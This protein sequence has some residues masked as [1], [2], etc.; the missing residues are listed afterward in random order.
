MVSA[1]GR[2]WQFP[3]QRDNISP[4]SYWILST[5]LHNPGAATRMALQIY[6]IRTRS[7][8]LNV[9]LDTYTT[10]RV[11]PGETADLYQIATK[12]LEEYYKITINHTALHTLHNV[13]WLINEVSQ[14]IHWSWLRSCSGS[15]CA[16]GNASAA[17]QA[18]CKAVV[19]EA[20][21][22]MS[23]PQCGTPMTPLNFAASCTAHGGPYH[24]NLGG[25]GPDGGA[26]ELRY[27]ATPRY[28]I[29]DT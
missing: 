28:L 24:N 26:E 27:V 5:E 21:T 22:T 14:L 8:T 9:V 17:D 6:L 19:T 4:A 15:P 2:F 20:P 10:L 13:R 1:V 12:L 3:F 7:P 23:L 11:P 18:C 16:V 29:L 25:I